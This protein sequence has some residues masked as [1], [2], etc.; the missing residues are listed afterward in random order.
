[1]VEMLNFETRMVNWRDT[2]RGSV[3]S[4]GDC[5]AAWAADY[6]S[7][8]NKREYLLAL[9]LDIVS[10]TSPLS[11]IESNALDGWLVEYA[12]RTL[13]QYDQK[14]LLRLKYVWDYPNHFIKNKLHINDASIRIVLG[15]AITNLNLVLDKLEAPDKIRAYNL[16]ARCVP[17]LEA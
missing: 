13:I 6:V 11:R 4:K 16:H 12:W 8:R 2:V 5:C 1:M 17:R 14:Q 15:R 7:N 10:P 3:S 9:S